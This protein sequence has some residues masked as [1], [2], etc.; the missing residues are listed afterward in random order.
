ME[1]YELQLQKILAETDR[2]A[3]G[4]VK[5]MK[6]DVLF[7]RDI[8][9]KYGITRDNCKQRVPLR[10]LIYPRIPLDEEVSRFEEAEKKIDKAVNDG[11]GR[12]LLQ[13]AITANV[14][15]IYWSPNVTFENIDETVTP[16]MR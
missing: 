9:R 15:M 1:N 10:N 4:I 14:E 2:K 3:I 7:V 5:Q 16:Y 6:D 13:S 12:G 11:S 8:F